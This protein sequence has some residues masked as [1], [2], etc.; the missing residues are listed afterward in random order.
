MTSDMK[1]LLIG[2]MIYSYIQIGDTP[3]AVE[4]F[5]HYWECT[6]RYHRHMLYLVKFC[7]F[8]LGPHLSIRK[9]YWSRIELDHEFVDKNGIWRFGEEVHWLFK[10]MWYQFGEHR[11]QEAIFA[12][13]R[14]NYL[15]SHPIHYWRLSECYM[16]LGLFR[17]A[18]NCMERAHKM[19]RGQVPSIEKAY[20]EQRTNVLVEL[21]GLRCG[22]CGKGLGDSKV[23]IFACCGCFAVH[24]CGRH[25]QKIGWTKKGH[26]HE[27]SGEFKAFKWKLKQFAKS[28]PIV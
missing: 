12:Y 25:C 1:T 14:C 7:S 15:A 8:L 6:Q 23:K 3:K 13:H 10:G 17:S 21:N 9:V 11:Y 26:R 24:Y 22:V 28:S 18:L 5:D 20:S 19:N 2:L 16:E 4:L 27:C